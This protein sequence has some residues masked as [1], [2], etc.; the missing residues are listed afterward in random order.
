MAGGRRDQLGAPSWAA[1]IAIVDQGRALAGKG[2]LDGPT[3]TLPTLYA[4]PSTGLH[5]IAASSSSSFS[6][7]GGSL[8]FG[9]F[10][11][12]DP[13]GGFGGFDQYS[14]FGW[15]DFG[16]GSIGGGTST[17]ATANTSTGLGTPNGQSLI[18]NLVASNTTTPLTT[19][20]G[21]GQ[22]GTGTTP[23]S[24]TPPSQPVGGGGKHHH[25]VTKHGK[26]IKRTAPHASTVSRH[27]LVAQK[28]ATEKVESH[29]GRRS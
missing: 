26:A 8:G 21:S 15:S 20:T 25:Q 22:S 6:A 27:R 12:F 5:A 14:F 13:F 16:F 10:G 4:A 7:G 19:I 23:T 18:N 17:G 28:S 29:H 2:S 24:P 3:Q 9:G 1:I 11:G